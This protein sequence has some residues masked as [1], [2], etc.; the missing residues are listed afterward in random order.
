MAPSHFVVGLFAAV[1][2]G[3][4][5]S[6]SP[7]A[8]ERTRSYGQTLT[9]S[10]T[11]TTTFQV[12]ADADQDPSTLMLD[13]TSSLTI[14]N[15]VQLASTT[16]AVSEG[17]GSVGVNAQVGQLDAYG[18]LSLGNHAVVNQLLSQQTFTG[19]MPCSTAATTAPMP[20]FL[21]AV[22][23]RPPTSPSRWP[24]ESRI[25]VSRSSPRSPRAPT[26]STHA[27]VRGV[28]ACSGRCVGS[29]AI[30][31][32]WA[33]SVSVA[34]IG[35]VTQLA[36]GRAPAAATLTLACSGG[37]STSGPNVDPSKQVVGLSMSDLQVVCDWT[38]QDWGGYG[39]QLVCEAGSRDSLD[40]PMETARHRGNRAKQRTGDASAETTNGAPAFA[41]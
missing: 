35:S 8:P 38:A 34:G 6:S 40:A 31:L 4:C 9:I 21:A 39:G 28:R 37:A 13:G 24:S 16:V 18:P 11:G 17:S 36:C 3:S 26:S 41:A 20:P 7:P 12:P 30:A 32:R 10:T 22:T 25:A 5:T 19:R 33:G 2:S 1:L 15:N 29:A 27:F 23:M 14:G